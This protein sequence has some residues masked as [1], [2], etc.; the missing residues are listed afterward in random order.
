[1]R[2]ASPHSHLLKF[3]LASVTSIFIGTMHGMLQVQPAIRAWLDSIGSPYGGPGHMIDPLAHAHINLVGGVTILT[4]GVIYYLF[5]LFSGKEIYSKRLVNQSF[6]WTLI[7]VL[8][9]YSAQMVF[10][11]W[12]GTLMLAGQVDAQNEVHR[13]YGPVVAVGGTVMAVGFLLYFINIAM[14]LRNPQKTTD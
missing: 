8:I 6:W 1:M 5:P 4:M 13:F 11:V 9:F 14:S 3:L 10:G 7:G 12:E 2:P